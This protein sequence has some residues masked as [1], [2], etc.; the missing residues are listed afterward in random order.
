M[1]Y[2][3]KIEHDVMAVLKYSTGSLFVQFKKAYRH[4]I[5]PPELLYFKGLMLSHDH[6]DHHIIR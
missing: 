4:W 6:K 1:K 2:E 5:D 3:K